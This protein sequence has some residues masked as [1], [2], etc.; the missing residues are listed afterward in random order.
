MPESTNPTG[1][2][3]DEKLKCGSCG[4]ETDFTVYV[5]HKVKRKQADE[6][7]ETEVLGENVELAT[8]DDCNWVVYMEDFTKEELDDIPENDEKGNGE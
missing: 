2:E 8:C 1:A 3:N 5:T 4:N 6:E 7:I